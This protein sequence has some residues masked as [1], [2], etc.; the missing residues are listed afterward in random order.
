MSKSDVLDNLSLDE[1][2]A[3][4]RHVDNDRAVLQRAL[5]QKRQQTKRAVI[6]EVKELIQSRGHEVSDILGM[7]TIKKKA[8]KQPRAYARYIDPENPENEYVR[9]VLP[10]WMKTQMLAQGLNP[11]SKTDR[12]LFKDQKLQKKSEANSAAEP[13]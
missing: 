8:D 6:Q 3:R 9:G 13:K 11:K 10:G 4:L 2:Q 7:I 12:K 5:Q 1:I